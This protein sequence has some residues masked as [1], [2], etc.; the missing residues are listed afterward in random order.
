MRASKKGFLFSLIALMAL[1]L[2]FSLISVKIFEIEQQRKTYV[3]GIKIMNYKNKLALIKNENLQKL[4]EDLL[5]HH[6]YLLANF[7]S[8]E[9]CKI[10]NGTRDGKEDV[11]YVK[12]ALFYLIKNG[13]ISNEFLANPATNCETSIERE[14]NFDNIKARY[15]DYLEKADIYLNVFETAEFEGNNEK[16]V[17]ELIDYKTIQ[18]NTTY[19]IEVADK[20]GAIIIKSHVNISVNVSIEG[21]PDPLVNE[22]LISNGFMNVKRGI[23]F[24]RDNGRIVENFQEIKKILE[25]TTEQQQ[26]FMENAIKGQGWSYGNFTDKPDYTQPFIMF[27][28]FDEVKNYE[29]DGYIV[30]GTGKVKSCAGRNM[31]KDMFNALDYSTKSQSS[32]SGQFIKNKKVDEMFIMANETLFETFLNALKKD[33]NYLIITDSKLLKET[34]FNDPTKV[35]EVAKA[36][37]NVTK[38]VVYDI[39]EARDIV[40]NGYYVKYAKAPS[41]FQRMVENGYELQGGEKGIMSFLVTEEFVKKQNNKL[42]PISKADF[43]HKKTISKSELVVIKGFPGCKTAKMCKITDTSILSI[44]KFSLSK[45][46][47]DDINLTIISCTFDNAENGCYD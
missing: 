45:A 35:E 47:A 3:E 19:K 5:M 8:D 26:L 10:K 37:Y 14:F 22:L 15:K 9:N 4:T 38:I 40:A 1:L 11:Y 25:I 18:M 24:K 33:H 16:T 39:E 32:C 6:V 41:F 28:S 20:E 34:Y 42:L 2:V 7:T 17:I 21:M 23:K 46:L 13:T 43:E 30:N 27:G 12:K 36:K 29:A 31:E 44:G